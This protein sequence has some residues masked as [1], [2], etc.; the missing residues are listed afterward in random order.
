[1]TTSAWD[2]SFLAKTGRPHRRVLS[3][4]QQAVKSHDFEVL[5]DLPWIG[6]WSAD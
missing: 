5:C 3:V 4:Q 2:F 1:M 6:N